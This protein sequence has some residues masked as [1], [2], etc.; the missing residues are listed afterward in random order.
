[1]IHTWCNTYVWVMYGYD[2]I[3]Y[4][5]SR[6]CKESQEVVQF[7]RKRLLTYPQELSGFYV[8]T[9]CEE[10]S[11]QL[12]GSQIVCGFIIFIWSSGLTII[13]LPCHSFATDTIYCLIASLSLF[14][15]SQFQH[16]ACH[17]FLWL[18]IFMIFFPFVT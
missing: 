5:Y 4:I 3:S 6:N 17:K 8:A 1:M 2:L 7:I 15:I 9:I 12:I 16:A 18:G 11:R 13:V 10:V 14:L